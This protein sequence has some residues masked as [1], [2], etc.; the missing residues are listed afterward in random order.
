VQVDLDVLASTVSGLDE[1]VT[2]DVGRNL[3]ASKVI[4]SGIAV[5]T[6]GGSLS[7]SQVNSGSDV[8]LAVTGNVTR[9]T[10][11]SPESDAT[12]TV[13]GNFLASSVT[14]DEDM[15]I[16]VDGNM[17]G[18]VNSFDS[19]ISL[20]VNGTMSGKAIAG[21]TLQVDVG[22]LTG[23]LSSNEL[24][25]LVEGNVASSARIQAREV[26]DF[27]ADTIG[28]S[29]GGDFGGVLSVLDFDSDVVGG[30]TLVDGDVLKSARFNIGRT[31][32][33]NTDEDFIFGGNFLGVF[34]LAGSMDVDLAFGGNVNQVIIG[35]F[36]GVAGLPNV[37]TVSGKLKFL[38]SGSLFAESTR[39][40]EGDF[41]SGNGVVTATLET[42]DGFVTVTPMVSS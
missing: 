25:L 4:S 8:S 20:K 14:C 26:D 15:F 5:I 11:A 13:G 16:W 2:L 6:V 12:V 33:D 36:V 1:A 42:R 7:K 34:N 10:I 18:T 31:F 29:V 23:S 35:G 22:Q 24:D 40:K 39:G 27:N 37:I 38:T 9:S 30:S 41:R 21:D 32:G 3:T 28:F 17:S 19:S